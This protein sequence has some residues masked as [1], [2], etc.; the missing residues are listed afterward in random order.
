VARARTTRG[1]AGEGDLFTRAIETDPGKADPGSTP[2]AERMRPRSLD[3]LVGQEKLVGE[4]RP[5]R[6]AIEADRVPSLI[7]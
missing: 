3:E 2:L 1:G 5:L 6:R 4:G 7:L